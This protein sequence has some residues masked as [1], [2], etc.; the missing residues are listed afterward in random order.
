MVIL[1][2]TGGTIYGLP[3]IFEILYIPMQQ[4]MN[5]SKTQMGGLMAL[6]GGV[7]MAGYIPGGWLADRF[8]P[9]KLITIG[10]IASGMIYAAPGFLDYLQAGNFSS[11]TASMDGSLTYVEP[12]REFLGLLIAL[13]IVGIYAQRWRTS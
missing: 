8:S 11:I 12:A 5:L 10:M 6:F 3:Y 1:C 9:R 4:A 13:T 2:I 7:C